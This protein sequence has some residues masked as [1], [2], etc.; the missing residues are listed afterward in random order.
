MDTEIRKE[1]KVQTGCDRFTSPEEISA[2]SKYLK[3]KRQDLDDSISL[4]KDNLGVPG[5]RSGSLKEITSLSDKVEVLDTRGNSGII[6]KLK[7][8]R[9]TL[10]TNKNVG[11]LEK[12]RE[13][14][15]GNKK[16]TTLDDDIENIAPGEKNTSLETKR[17]NLKINDKTSLSGYIDSIIDNQK[18]PSLSND[19]LDIGEIK[20][21]NLKKERE[22]VHF[23]KE[24]DKNLSLKR[25]KD[26]IIDLE[27][28]EKQKL[29]YN[30]TE[31]LKV[32]KTVDALQNKLLNIGKNFSE[33]ELKQQE[34]NIIKGA[35]ANG[36]L[37]W[38][39]GE[40]KEIESLK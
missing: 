32:E 24:I 20:Y 26:A 33:N 7:D 16:E 10:T 6:S 18:D 37:I 14:I 29:D 21:P 15:L 9:E 2:L 25:G 23:A 13:T 1:N 19:R 35:S 4:G 38:L 31:R 28:D 8:N 39:S 3:K 11:T 22:N 36:S 34:E 17:E 30:L 12:Q 27:I 5:W 40:N